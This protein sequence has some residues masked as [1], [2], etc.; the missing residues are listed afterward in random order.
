MKSYLVRIDAQ[1]GAGD[2]L[3]LRLASHDHHAVCHLDGETWWPFIARLPALR[4]DFFGGDFRGAITAPVANF[5]AAILGWP[6]FLSARFAG[7]RFRLWSGEIGG[8]FAS[9]TLRFDGLIS[10]EPQIE[11]G[12]AQFE[13][14]PDDAWLDKPLLTLFEGTGG[15]EGPDDLEG[16]PKPLA[17][18]TLRF[19]AGTQIDAVDNIW[20]VSGHGAIEGVSAVYDRV[21]SLGASYGDFASIG[22][23]QAATIPN[24]SWATCLT[25]GLIRLGAPADGKLSFDIE[26]DNAGAGGFVELPGEVI[27]RIAEIAGGT[28]DSANLAALDAACPWPLAVDITSQTTARQAIQEIADSCGGVAGISW[29]GTLFVQPL[30]FGT[31]S[32]TLATDGSAM[33]QVGEVS[34]LPVSAPFWRLATR[35]EPTWVVHDPGEV[36]SGYNY[37]GEWNA[38]RVYRLDDWVV[39]P[40]GSTWVYIYPTP[41][42][43][44]EPG[45]GSAY[46]AEF[47][48]GRGITTTRWPALP[49][50]NPVVGSLYFD[51]FMKPFR[52]EGYPLEFEEDPLEFE[53]SPLMGPGWVSVR[54]RALEDVVNDLQALDDDSVFTVVEKKIAIDRNRWLQN[55]YQGLLAQGAA[56]GY[57]TSALTAAWTSYVA[58]RDSISP[59]WN[60]LSQPSNFGGVPWDAVL[61]EL[62]QAIAAAQ[63]AITGGASITVVP[64]E[65][66]SVA[67]GANGAPD[68]GAYPRTLT[69]TVKRGATDI[70]DDDDVSYS[71]ATSGITAT[72][73]NTPGDPDKGKI[74]ATGGTSGHIDLTVSVAGVDFGPFRILFAAETGLYVANANGWAVGTRINGVIHWRQRGR[75]TATANT[76]GSQDFPVPFTD[77]SSIVITTG[78]SGSGGF[79]DQDNYPTYTG[80]PTTTGFTWRNP[81]DTTAV[82]GW[83]AEGF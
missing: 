71:I 35:A 74:T 44:N 42:S 38:V 60:D 33:P 34:A 36:A 82:M 26:G 58:V 76:S 80:D 10:G 49:P 12:I 6:G 65:N 4:Y 78:G 63:A 16:Q 47:E 21:A 3:V 67:V 56:V 77:A 31:A 17:L 39:M 45:P 27:G 28:T 1:D 53:G 59:A 8:D 62:E 5:S 23:L 43:G 32:L 7:A 64:P 25:E 75:V 83:I 41:S 15:L 57:D 19:A 73:N 68:T 54:D 13:A 48:G 81:D 14:G 69:P 52:F 18:G 2:P 24:G 20:C 51:Q 72:I 22:V 55:V 11:R 70:R 30:A 50:D 79:N 40:D 29:T 9:Y 37:R 61:D 46:W 66:Q